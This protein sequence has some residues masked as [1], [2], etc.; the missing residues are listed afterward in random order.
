[1]IKIRK[2]L[3]EKWN[4][5][6]DS[7]SYESKEGKKELDWFMIRVEA[8]FAGVSIGLLSMM[9][10]C[11]RGCYT[12]QQRDRRVKEEYP[13]IYGQMAML[14]DSNS[15][16]VFDIL[17]QAEAWKNAT[18]QNR[19]VSESELRDYFPS[20]DAYEQYQHTVSTD[21]SKF[22]K[23]IKIAIS[24]LEQRKQPNKYLVDKVESESQ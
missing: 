10:F 12:E 19:A 18:G 11:A 4:D 21:Y 1:M 2:Y 5:C 13:V 3:R 23:R 16:G 24:A 20:P 15:N 7:H 8:I 6:V 22:N 14:Y 9:G 17:E